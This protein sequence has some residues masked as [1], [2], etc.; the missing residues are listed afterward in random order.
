MSNLELQINKLIKNIMKKLTKKIRNKIK[1]TKRKELERYC[2]DFHCSNIDQE[3][4]DSYDKN[5]VRECFMEGLD[6]VCEQ[7]KERRKKI[8]FLKLILKNLETKT[9]KYK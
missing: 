6:V 7:L 4:L 5:E 8:K 1:E 9:H 2:F 3:Y